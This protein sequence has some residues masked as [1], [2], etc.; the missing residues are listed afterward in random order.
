[1][2]DSILYSNEVVAKA[3]DEA[4]EEYTEPSWDLRNIAITQ[5][6]SFDQTIWN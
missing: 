6:A 2:A 4:A 1:M 5:K 3:I